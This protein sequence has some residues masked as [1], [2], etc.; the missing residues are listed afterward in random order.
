MYAKAPE[1]DGLREALLEFDV[2]IHEALKETI[3]DGIED[4]T[5]EE[6][7]PEAA[8][9]MI[10]AAHMSTFLR[11]A[12]GGETAGIKDGL[13]EFILSNFRK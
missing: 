6:V 10:F 5:F 8:A 1:Y 4:G 3:R 13:D 2:A 7:D 11:K 9:D 12:V